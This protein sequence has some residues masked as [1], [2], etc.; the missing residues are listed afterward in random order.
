MTGQTCGQVRV[1][2][3]RMK[4]AGRLL[5]V[6]G[7][8]FDVATSGD[9]ASSIRSTALA[10]AAS[11]PTAS[12]F[13]SVIRRPLC[14]NRRGPRGCPGVDTVSAR[15]LLRHRVEVKRW[16]FTPLACAEAPSPGQSPS[17]PTPSTQRPAILSAS[18]SLLAADPQESHIL[19]SFSAVVL[20]FHPWLHQQAR[21]RHPSLPSRFARR[22][23]KRCLSPRSQPPF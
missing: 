6:S 13:V 3:W 8:S 22:H 19:C 16:N 18:L 17:T 20:R 9:L 12:C 5:L 11:P 1:W 2:Q 23:G 21:P 10:P 7:S 14:A 15:L 4:A